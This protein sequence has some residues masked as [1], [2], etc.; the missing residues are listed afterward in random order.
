MSDINV[1][2]NE[3][4]KII[5][6]SIGKKPVSISN[7]NW[8][9]TINNYSDVDECH[10]RSLSESLDDNKIVKMGYNFEIAPSTGMKHIQG[11]ITFKSVKTMSGVK[12]LLGNNSVHLEVMRGSI[13]DNIEYCSK[14]DTKDPNKESV[15]CIN[16]NQGERTELIDC[17][18]SIRL[19][20]FNNTVLDDNH[21]KPMSH[22]IKAMQVFDNIYRNNQMELKMKSYYDNFKLRNWQKDVV[23]I[24]EQPVNNRKI[25]WVWEHKGNVGKSELLNYLC[26]KYNAV[27]LSG[28]VADMAYAYN[29]EPIVCFDIPRTAED[30][31]GKQ[32]SIRHLYNFAEKLKNKRVFSS[33]YES[34]SKI[35]ECPHVIFF[36]NFECDKSIWSEDRYNIINLNKNRDFN[37]REF[38][39]VPLINEAESRCVVDQK[40]TM[41]GGNLS[42]LTNDKKCPGNTILDP[43]CQKKMMP[44]EIDSW[45][46]DITSEWWDNDDDPLELCNNDNDVYLHGYAFKNDESLEY[47]EDDDPL[48][49]VIDDSYKLVNES[50]VTPK[51]SKVKRYHPMKYDS[52]Y[53]RCD[54]CNLDGFKCKCELV[55]KTFYDKSLNEWVFKWCIYSLKHGGYYTVDP[56]KVNWKYP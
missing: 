15:L 27:E 18:E 56:M 44:R 55:K 31:D 16:D 5:G 22:C 39:D 35:F 11:F 8:A 40:E 54:M 48:N 23:D 2:S 47:I 4:S 32:E 21:A 7:R 53:D 41:H 43:N 46:R 19:N 51:C 25:H 34:R 20:G 1:L 14:S 28:K 50:V 17:R 6:K 37:L 52:L 3:V 29:G 26:V 12:K 49:Y 9:F 30:V 24:I 38:I 33:K 45:N 10:M 42:D 13:K 36:A